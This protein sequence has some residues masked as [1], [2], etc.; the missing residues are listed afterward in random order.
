MK[1]IDIIINEE[2]SKALQDFMAMNPPAITAQTGADIMRFRSKDAA[3][4]SKNAYAKLSPEEKKIADEYLRT[5]DKAGVSQNAKDLGMQRE[6][7][8]QGK[9]KTVRP[10]QEAEI[11]NGNGTKTVVD[12]KTANM[13]KDE[14]SGKVKV[15]PKTT[16]GVAD[17]ATQIKPGD[18]V[19]VDETSGRLTTV[20]KDGKTTTTSSTGRVKTTIDKDGMKVEPGDETSDKDDDKNDDVAD[21]KK[22]AGL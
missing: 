11:D 22:L 6:V 17:P 1:M 7:S 20:K 4:A 12:L 21:V 2:H 9:I 16:K 5:K 18:E 8:E 19:E 10:G 14:K 13:V 3:M 15:V